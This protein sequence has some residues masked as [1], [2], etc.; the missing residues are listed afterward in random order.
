MQTHTACPRHNVLT[1]VAH[2]LG[3]IWRTDKSGGC[4]SERIHVVSSSTQSLNFPYE[5]DVKLRN[6]FGILRTHTDFCTF[7]LSF[8]L[9]TKAGGPGMANGASDQ[10]RSA[11]L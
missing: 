11:P 9:R 6:Y 7:Q 1:A 8:V 3:G 4:C 5:H 10:G 2:L